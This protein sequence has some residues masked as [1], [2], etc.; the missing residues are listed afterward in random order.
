LSI[1]TDMLLHSRPMNAIRFSQEDK[2]SRPKLK[3]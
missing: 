1:F 3:D 2:K